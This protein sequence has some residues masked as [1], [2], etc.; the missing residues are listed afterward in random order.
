ME[1]QPVMKFALACCCHDII[2]RRARYPVFLSWDFKRVWLQLAC[3]S[4]WCT[5]YMFDEW[6]KLSGFSFIQKLGSQN[7]AAS[8]QG[9]SS[10]MKLKTTLVFAT[11]LGKSLSTLMWIFENVTF[12]KF[13]VITKWAPKNFKCYTRCKL[14]WKTLTYQLW[15]KFLHTLGNSRWN[16]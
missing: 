2:Y 13:M 12:Q 10:P 3:L 9:R 5:N 16:L 11:Q 4:W 7:D 15:W 8:V 14:P 6:T 1:R